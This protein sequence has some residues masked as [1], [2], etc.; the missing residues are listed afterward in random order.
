MN[1]T[2][3]LWEIIDLADISVRIASQ[4]RL[5]KAG[6]PLRDRQALEKGLAFLENAKSGGIF[7]SGQG[8]IRGFEG[9]LRP[10][11]WA[12]D[13][14]LRER[15]AGEK[16]DY[17]KIA[18]YMAEIQESLGS[19]LQQNRVES[20]QI[21]NGITFFETMGELLSARADQSLQ[22]Q[23]QVADYHQTALWF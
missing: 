22:K 11:N 20:E 2:Q 19:L 21:D 3:A 18:Q 23:P 5:S 14:Y 16:P 15:P 13:T 7:L 10:L 9:T 6:K 8:I 1:D 4:L 12:M 17:S